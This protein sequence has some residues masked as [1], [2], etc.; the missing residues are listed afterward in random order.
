MVYDFAAVIVSF[1]IA[2]WLRFDCKVTSVE[3]Q[4]LTTYTKTIIVY[5]LFCLVVFWFLRLYKSIWRFASYSELLRVI[6]ATV[7]TG[8]IYT[9]SLLVFNLHMPVSYYVIGITVQFIA[10]LGIRFFYRFVLLLRG[11]TNNE[12]QKKNVMIIGAGSAGQ[13]LFRDIKHAKETNE[14]VACFIDD[15]PNKWDRY[16]D[17]VPVFGSRDHILEAVDKFNIEKIYVAVPSANPQDKR[18]ILR[19]CNETSC[20]L[21]N[22]PGMYQLYTGEVSVSKMKKVQIEDLLGR[23]PI[24]PNMDEVFA[25]VRNKVVLITGVGS[26]G[27]ELARQIASHNPKQLILFDVYENNAYDIQLELR[28]KYPNLDLVTLIGSVRD[29]RKMF[30]LF[31]KYRPQIVYHAAAHKHV[32]LMEDSPCESIKNN[33]MGTY[34]TAYAAMVH[35]C[36]KFVLISTDKAVNPTNIMGASKRLCEMIIQA[37]AAKIKEGKAYEIPQLFTHEKD[38]IEKPEI[39]EALKTTTTEFVAVRF[40]NVLGSNG[41]VIPI[42]KRQIEAGGPVT[43]THPDIIRYFM[44][45]PEAVSL[46]LLAGTY[47]HGG[48]IFVLDMGEPVKITTLARNLIRL[49]GYTPDVDIKLEFTGLRPGEKLYEEKLMAEE[50]LKKTKNDL[51]HI[52]CPIPFDINEFLGELDGLLDAAYRN[53][54]DMKERVQKI[55][56]TYHPA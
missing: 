45:I 6:L 35:G 44:T 38:M 30:D 11:R 56:S 4:Y 47:A 19:V 22:L 8:V 25:Y 1:G 32:P 41:S 46:V 27:S 13:M 28:K 2:L 54:D 31:K 17:D 20:E 9:G 14:T 43:V 15:N 49:S 7:V 51:I 23:D 48:E 12:V 5:A 36:E 18:D 33:A 29:S 34:K 53:E 10:T 26:I 40:G 52:G 24:K 3:P 50:G 21:M 37:F 16:I 55:V 42:F 39:K